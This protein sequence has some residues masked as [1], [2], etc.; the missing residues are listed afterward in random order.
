[1]TAVITNFTTIRRRPG[2]ILTPAQYR[3]VVETILGILRT[4]DF[5]DF[6][7]AYVQFLD[8]I[9]NFQDPHKVTQTDFG[10]NIIERTHAIYQLMCLNPLPLDRFKTEIVP[11]LGFLELIRRIVLNR[12]L[13]NQVKNFDGSVSQTVDVWLGPDWNY[14]LQ[15]QT[16]ITLSFGTKLADEAAFLRK[17]WTVNTTPIP[18]VFNGENLVSQIIHR[19]CVFHTSVT[20]PYFTFN[21]QTKDY[22]AALALA[23][24]DVSL[25][26]KSRGAPTSTINLAT[27]RNATDRLDVTMSPDTKIVVKLNGTAISASTFCDGLEWSLDITRRGGITLTTIHGNRQTLAYTT[28][29]FSAVAPFTSLQIG[30]ALSNATSQT[31]GLLELTASIVSRRFIPPHTS[32]AT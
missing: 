26:A 11:T 32:L 19:T 7:D 28:G 17:G 21:G 20:S 2:D 1:M 22:M 14:P 30:Q 13:Y 5:S 4:Y 29:N 31:P 3:S 9:Q 24:N 8:H 27:L 25:Q 6:N 16:P 18:V 15:K 23:S 12:Y 10:I